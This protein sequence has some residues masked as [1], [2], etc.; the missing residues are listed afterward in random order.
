[1]TVED[2]LR[3]TFARHEAETP[4][5]GQLRDKIKTAVVRRQRRRAITASAV[6]V[7]ALGVAVPV[8]L[9]TLGATPATP[10]PAVALTQNP[11]PIPATGLNVLLIG[12]DRAVGATAAVART[13]L[14]V[15]VTADRKHVY[16]VSLPSTGV[17]AGGQSLAD[18]YRGGGVAQTRKAVTGLT[19]LTFGTTVTV[20]PAAMRAVT[21]AVGGVTF[22][23]AG[24]TSCAR[25]GGAGVEKLLGGLGGKIDA[26]DE[27]SQSFLI[28]L[29]Y[30]LADT[31]SLG[32]PAELQHLV[33]VADHSGLGVDGDLTVLATVAQSLNPAAVVG[34]RRT[35]EAPSEIYPADVGQSLYAALRSDDLAT[36]ASEHPGYVHKA[37]R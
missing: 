9:R 2:E 26:L 6:A 24:G 7:L 28:G 35:D 5:A 22:C 16:L 27:T 8:G 15:H 31:K 37:Q 17:V 36:W 25:R 34:I 14:I 18:T 33:T 20:A 3:A 23:A 30:R 19:G 13:V 10:L 32:D 1:M 11:A 12:T 4:P 29:A 21:D